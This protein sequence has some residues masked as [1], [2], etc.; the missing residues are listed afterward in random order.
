MKNAVN[1]NSAN[2]KIVEIYQALT[3]SISAYQLRII[4]KK[5]F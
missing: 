2:S 5:N 4:F 1:I 3:D